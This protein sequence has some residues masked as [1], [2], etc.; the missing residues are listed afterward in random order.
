MVPGAGYEIVISATVNPGTPDDTVLSQ[1]GDRQLAERQHAWQ[2]HGHRHDDRG[3]HQADVSVTK[4]DGITTV[5][6]GD[7]VVRTYTIT[8]SNAGPS[9]AAA[10][11]LADTWPAG[12]ARDRHA[13][14]GHL[15]RKPE[16]H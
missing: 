1:L 8:V 5:T 10:V 3:R 16:L 14:P 7:G 9:N 15:R 12:H 2:Q 13:V 4:S 6:A 11:S